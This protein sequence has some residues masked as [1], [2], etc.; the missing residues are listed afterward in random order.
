MFR[1]ALISMFLT[2][3][4]LADTLLVPEEYKTIQL[5][6]DA[7]SPGDVIDLASGT[8]Y[9]QIV[10]GLSGVTLKGRDGGTT[11]IDGSKHEWSPVVCY[12]EP[13]V[14]ENISFQNG[15]GSNVFGY[16]RGGAVYVEFSQV[17]IRNCVFENNSVDVGEIFVG[18][19][20]GGVCNYYGS[21]IIESCSFN[22]NTSQGS[23]E[24]GG[25]GA[26]YSTN[27]NLSITD[28]EFENNSSLFS[29]GGIYAEY[30]KN[31]SVTNCTFTGNTATSGGGMY[32]YSSSPT[33]TDCTFDNNHVT[34]TTGWGGA[35]MSYGGDVIV[36]NST[37]K[38]NTSKNYAGAVGGIGSLPT[39]S[40]GSFY[41]YN[42]EF[43]NNSTLGSKNIFGGGAA[44]A[45]AGGIAV[46]I[47]QCAFLNNT[48]HGGWGGGGGAIGIQIV[49]NDGTKASTVIKNSTFEN[50]Y[51]YKGESFA[52]GGAIF[53]NVYDV[54]PP[55]CLI[56]NC[57]FAG[58]EATNSGGAIYQFQ[59]TAE[60]LNISDSTF[61]DSAPNHIDGKL[62]WIDGGGNTFADECP[63][64]PDITG[65]GYVNVSDLL[66]IIDQWGQTNSPADLNYDGIV[67]VSDL[68]IVVGDWGECE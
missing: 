42:C 31:Y 16:I 9:N 37:F 11:V 7:S 23:S 43:E 67:D 17:T 62:P 66:T 47:D 10:W 1:T 35:I 65:D 15:V 49:P 6:M 19:A 12:G 39:E 55:V 52:Y 21:L 40:W 20:G 38:N 24:F 56:E 25:G 2:S 57:S 50:N 36:E 28:S 32:C 41:L 64:C 14:I 54:L 3:A 63:D 51:A 48:F 58:N 61:C 46:E 5:A 8:W 44:C 4:A 29:G 59:Q 34:A 27:G 22:N 45:F 53:F 26:V 33:L 18:A 30:A 68:L 13:A 60:Y